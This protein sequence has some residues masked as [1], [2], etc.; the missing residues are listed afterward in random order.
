M[1]QPYQTP[2]P[3]NPPPPPAYAPPQPLSPADERTWAMLAHMSILLNLITGFVGTLAA[4]AIYL[5]LQ[6]RSRYVAYQSLQALI[7]QSLAWIVSGLIAITLW[8]LGGILSVVCVGV[9]LFPLA[10]FFTLIPIAAVVYGVIGGIQ[11]YEGKDFKYWLVGD[12]V[13]GTLGGVPGTV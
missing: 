2:Q 1:E 12:W 6:D 4:L 7:F 10:I 9:L 5:F 13:R 8:T 11:T 3:V